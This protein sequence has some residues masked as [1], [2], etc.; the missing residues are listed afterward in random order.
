MQG[1]SEDE[2][3]RGALANVITDARQ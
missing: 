2:A 3:L 1:M